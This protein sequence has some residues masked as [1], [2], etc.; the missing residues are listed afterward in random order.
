MHSR[1]CLSIPSSSSLA[2]SLVPS[3]D[4]KSKKF[5]V[6]VTRVRVP[7][8]PFLIQYSSYNG[9]GVHFSLRGR[10]RLGWRGRE[11]S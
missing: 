6:T 10:T 4:F 8:L 9:D 3:N 1:D 2:F 11:Y 5:D 7:I